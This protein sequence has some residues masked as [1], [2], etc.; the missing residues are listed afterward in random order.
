[1]QFEFSRIEQ[2]F[3]I[4]LFPKSFWNEYFLLPEQPYSFGQRILNPP[5][6]LN[7]FFKELFSEYQIE[8]TSYMHNMDIN[9]YQNSELKFNVFVTM[10][11]D[12]DGPET[13]CTV[14]IKV[15]PRGDGE[16]IFLKM[17]IFML[18]QY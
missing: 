5:K 8:T 11:I 7:N 9:G 16:K 17:K 15:D 1:M 14:Q 18:S 10:Y 4:I 3:L 13:L 12:T 2:K 6:I